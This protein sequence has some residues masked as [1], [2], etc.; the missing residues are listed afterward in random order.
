MKKIN[1]EEQ[2]TSYKFKR[3]LPAHKIILADSGCMLTRFHVT[4]CSHC[5][6]ST[7]KKPGTIPSW[8][9]QSAIQ[10]FAAV[11]SEM[12]SRNSSTSTK[13]EQLPITPTFPPL[14]EVQ[15]TTTRIRLSDI[16]N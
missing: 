15:P 8:M 13:T 12:Q 1:T 4:D 14:P 9:K 5:K 2:Q 16:L 7:N 11:S 3:K 10:V 6:L